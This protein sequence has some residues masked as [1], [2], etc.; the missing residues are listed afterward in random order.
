MTERKPLSISVDVETNKLQLKLRAIAKHTE[1][2]ADEL[3]AI[4]NTWQCDCG[5]LNYT[6]HVYPSGSLTTRVCNGCKESYI[7]PRCE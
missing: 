3:D 7:V 1:A 6:D 2:L 4:D 5:S